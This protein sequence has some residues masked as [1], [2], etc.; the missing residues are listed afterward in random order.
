MA[1]QKQLS[2]R[3]RILLSAAV[4]QRQYTQFGSKVSDEVQ[5]VLHPVGNQSTK[6]DNPTET[7][8]TNDA[9]AP[10]ANPTPAPY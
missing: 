1:I 5:R 4:R 7:I 6:N 9:T 8:T 3:L 10:R 2:S